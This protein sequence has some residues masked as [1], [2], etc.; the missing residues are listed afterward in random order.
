MKTS[1]QGKVCEDRFI[2]ENIIPRN[3]KILGIDKRKPDTRGGWPD[4]ISVKGGEV[5]VYEVKSGNHKID[6]HQME[7]LKALQ[8]LGAIV[9]LVH[10][11]TSD[12][13]P[14]ETVWSRH[15]EIS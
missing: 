15:Q 1:K 3:H 10:F 13:E 11:E 6:D 2:K 12:S 14:T 8:S 4:I 7:V 9:H 5:H